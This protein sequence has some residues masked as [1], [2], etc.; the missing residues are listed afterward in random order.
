MQNKEKRI[1]ISG[2]TFDP[3]HNG[4]LIIAE[5]VREK[6]NLDRVIFIPSGNPP[7]KDNSKV[8]SAEHRYA[9]LCDS[10]SSNRYFE[11]SRI[12]MERP[13]YTYTIDT[14]TQ[15]KRILDCDSRLFFITG[16]DII[17]EF[18]TWKR[19]QQVFGMCEFISVLRPGFGEN[20]FV[21]EI[22]HL[23]EAYGAKIHLVRAPLIQ[24]S[25]SDI[26]ERIKNGLSVKY[27]VPEAVEKYIYENRLYAGGL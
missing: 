11:S 17:P 3:V 27:L 10:I 9:M 4:H 24:I 20:E 2:G 13:G 23:R 7:H 16:A 1:G 8:T 12:E 19:Y 14:L 6:F 5:D 18:L 15:L 22:E 21:N 26:R 25:S